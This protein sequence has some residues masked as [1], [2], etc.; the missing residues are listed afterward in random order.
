MAVAAPPLPRQELVSHLLLLWS[1]RRIKGLASRDQLVQPLRAYRRRLLPPFHPLDGVQLWPLRALGHPRAPLLNALVCFARLLT[2][3][4]R[5]VVPLRLLRVSD[6]QRS[7]Q[8][9]ESRF[10]ALAS[11]AKLPLGLS[12]VLDV[13]RWL[14]L[15]LRSCR[16]RDG[17]RHGSSQAGCEKCG[18]QRFVH[19]S[20]LEYQV[21]PTHNG[22]GE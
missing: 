18:D 19:T 7:V 21:N 2:H 6:L 10:D 20:L 16:L 1:E 5:E 13:A 9:G 22:F 14:S 8:V 11:Q 17:H 12:I 15:R 3:D 4:R